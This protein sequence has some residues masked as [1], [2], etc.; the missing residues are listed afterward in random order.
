MSPFI[1]NTNIPAAAANGWAHVVI[2]IN[3]A[4]AGIDGC[5]GFVFHK[6]VSQYG[7]Q[8]ANDFQG[9]FWI[10][11]VI[12][13][14][15]AGPPPPPKISLPVKATQG[16]N[17]FASTAGVYDRQSAVLRQNSGLSWVGQATPANPVT[18]SFTIAGYPSSVNCEAWMF[19]VPNPNYLDGAPDWNETNC[20]IV[21]LQGNSSSATA[22][23]QYKVNEP[24]N[25]I[26]YSGGDP[27][28]NAPG[29]W[30]GVTTNYLESGNLASITNNGVLGTW[31]VKFTSDTNVTLIAPNGNSTNFIFPAYNVGLFAEQA[32][33]GFYVYLGMQANNADALNQ[34]VVYSNFAITGTG[35]PFSE[36]F[37]TDTVLDTTNTWNTSAA[38]GPKGVFVAPAGSASWVS[39]TLPDSGFSLQV[40]PTLN[41]PTAWTDPSTGPIIGM[42]GIRSQLL[43]S[44]EIPAGNTAFYRLIKRQFTQLQV[45]LPGETNAPN[46]LTGKVGAPSAVNPGDPVIVTVN[47]VDS[48]FHIVSSTDSITLTSLTDNAAT[49][50]VPGNLA[51]GTAQMYVYFGTS[52]SQT[53]TATD[54]TNTNI[55]AA[56]SSPQPVN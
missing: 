48:T 32:S 17:V 21:Y 56:T 18:Y 22:H 37:L 19:L 31:K 28:T 6:W 50:P 27:W 49:L 30:D 33:P 24:N 46:T 43:A 26:M 39:W 12:L 29:S 44:N 23:F 16:L 55:P 20:A 14:G 1:I 53:I 51:G 7:G 9:R 34:A 35:S 45:L 10:D 36:N 52:G 13:Q 42:G 40:S 11:N 3:A 38:A 54:T 25:Q 8:I 41:N 5:S 47:S 4:T 2:P 15:T